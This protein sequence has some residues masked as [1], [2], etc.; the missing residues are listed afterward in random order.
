MENFRGKGTSR[1]K[2]CKGTDI[3]KHAGNFSAS[4]IHYQSLQQKDYKVRMKDGQLIVGDHTPLS[5]ILP[6]A[7]VT[8]A[9]T[10]PNFKTYSQSGEHSHNEKKYEAYRTLTKFSAFGWHSYLDY[11]FILH[12]GIYTNGD[13][14]YQF[15]NY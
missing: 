14:D 7:L 11:S 10:D 1:D 12:I 8:L 2:F 4:T 5:D 13:F 15:P 6:E 3:P 9:I